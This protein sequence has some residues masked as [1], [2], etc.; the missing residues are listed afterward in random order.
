MTCVSFK[1]GDRISFDLNIAERERDAPAGEHR[2]DQ[3]VS[4]LHNVAVTPLWLITSLRSRPQSGS[5]DPKQLRPRWDG[6]G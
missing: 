6:G 4:D 1:K 5:R 3:L 2:N